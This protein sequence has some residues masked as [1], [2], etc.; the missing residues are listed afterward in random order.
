MEDMGKGH[1]FTKF[2]TRRLYMSKSSKTKKNKVP[3]ISEAEYAE[4]ISGL[5]NLPEATKAVDA[6]TTEGVSVAKNQYRK[7]G[8]WLDCSPFLCG[9][10]TFFKK[11][12]FF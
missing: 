5:K 1:T 10:K 8:A 3:K 11:T 4:Y 9:E 6:R 7:R 12:D 2:Q